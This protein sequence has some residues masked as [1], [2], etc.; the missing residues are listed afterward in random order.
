[1][2]IDNVKWITAN[3]S[4]LWQAEMACIHAS[5]KLKREICGLNIVSQNLP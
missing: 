2:R 5:F 1:M 3:C 4:Q